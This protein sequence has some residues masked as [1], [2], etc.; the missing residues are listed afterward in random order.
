VAACGRGFF[1]DRIHGQRDH[2]RRPLKVVTSSVKRLDYTHVDFNSFS[3][4]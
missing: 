3:G 2:A 1:G 4:A